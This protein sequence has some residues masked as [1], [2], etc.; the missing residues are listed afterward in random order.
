MCL[1]DTLGIQGCTLA[2]FIIL[3]LQ[4]DFSLGLFFC[5]HM[6]ITSVIMSS[7]ASRSGHVLKTWIIN[8]KEEIIKPWLRGQEK[9]V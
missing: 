9:V 7:H 3:Q 2:T 6:I 4:K 8:T 1:P 5:G